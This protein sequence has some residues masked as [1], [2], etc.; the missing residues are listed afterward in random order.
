MTISPFTPYVN[1]ILNFNVPVMVKS[2]D[3]VGN[4]SMQDQ[5]ITLKAVLKPQESDAVTLQYYIGDDVTATLLEGYLVQPPVMPNLLKPPFDGN[6]TITTAS[7][8]V[9]SGRF[10]I[11]PSIVSP[12]LVALNLNLVNKIRG[13]F[14]RA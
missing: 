12:Y 8:R 6:A 14:T 9:E 4:R 10:K 13:I 1:A 2:S 3:R 5:I 11:L 7:G